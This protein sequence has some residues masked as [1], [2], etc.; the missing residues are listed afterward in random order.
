MTEPPPEPRDVPTAKPRGADLSTLPGEKLTRPVAPEPMRVP[1]DAIY[2]IACAV[3]VLLVNI[4]IGMYAHAAD[5]TDDPIT[6]HRAIAVGLIGGLALALALGGIVVAIVSWCKRPDALRWAVAAIALNVFA[7]FG[8][9]VTR[10][11]LA[12]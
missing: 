12:I 3:C 4:G 10:A 8:V 11:V 9:G 6:G 5:T 1:V 2:S 7:F